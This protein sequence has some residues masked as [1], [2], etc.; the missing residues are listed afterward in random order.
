MKFAEIRES[1]ADTCGQT[2]GH[3]ES[4]RGRG[5]YANLSKNQPQNE[6]KYSRAKIFS[7]ASGVLEHK[8][9]R[10]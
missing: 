8:V 4:N 1:R 10:A 5:G 7:V 6:W 2:D 3:D 9:R